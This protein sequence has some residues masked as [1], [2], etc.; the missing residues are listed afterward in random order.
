[1]WFLSS[2]FKRLPVHNAR[3]ANRIAYVKAF[4]DV[5]RPNLGQIVKAEIACRI[6]LDAIQVAV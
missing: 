1:M 6:V 3:L 2:K 5:G 4:M